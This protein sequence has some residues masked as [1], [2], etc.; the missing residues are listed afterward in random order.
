M[1][2]DNSFRL[3]APIDEVWGTLL[4]VERVAPCM[5]GAQVLE[6]TSEDSYKVAV[7][8]KL[9]PMSMQYRGDVEIV[10]QDPQRRRAVMKANAKE[11][12]GQGT[13]AA[14]IEM[15]LSQE[16]EI[17]VCKMH[18]DVK[19]SGRAAAMGQGVIRDVSA[20]LV[21]EFAE[22][23]ATM[24]SPG[25]EAEGP[26]GGG[27]PP[28]APTAPEAPAGAERRARATAPGPLPPRPGGDEGTSLQAGALIARVV[29][30]RLQDPRTLALTAAV[31]ALVFLAL[32]VLLGWLL[33]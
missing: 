31:Y 18:T 16:G 12:R 5:P 22:N 27:A 15:S 21:S 13:A 28:T 7:R 9:G 8:V 25:S 33:L 14:E 24:V 26:A 32:G 19:L 2:F 20:Q 17:T 23:L 30:G 29:A 4:D 3:E 10:E 6:R 1:L 11:A